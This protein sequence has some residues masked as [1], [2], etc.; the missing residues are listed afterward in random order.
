LAQ[1]ETQDAHQSENKSEIHISLQRE[2]AL[3][4]AAK[5]HMGFPVERKNS[6][7]SPDWN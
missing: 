4:Q 7:V 5:R 6:R 3:F 1:K 2:F